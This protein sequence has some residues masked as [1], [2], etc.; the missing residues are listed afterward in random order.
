MGCMT[1]AN[2]ELIQE[3]F[4]K[5]SRMGLQEW[6]TTKKQKK[7]GMSMERRT[8]DMENKR[9]PRAH[10]Y[11][12]KKNNIIIY[13]DFLSPPSHVKSDNTH[14]IINIH[15]FPTPLQ[16]ITTRAREGGPKEHL[17]KQNGCVKLIKLHMH[18]ISSLF[19]IYRLM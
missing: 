10:H 11:V 19:P 6:N 2:M 16:V 17:A 3:C 4:P 12:I 18:Q 7:R 15:H 1:I 8:A 5:H 13:H 14:P 9:S